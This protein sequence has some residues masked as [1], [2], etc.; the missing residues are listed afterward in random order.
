M[1]D[2]I[3]QD[4]QGLVSRETYFQMKADQKA[5]QAIGS[6]YRIYR[7][8]LLARRREFYHKIL[9][10][11][12]PNSE[13]CLLEPPAKNECYYD[14]KYADWYEYAEKHPVELPPDC[15][16]TLDS[17]ALNIVYGIVRGKEYKKI[18]QKINEG[19]NPSKYAIHSVCDHYGINTIEFDKT[20][21]IPYGS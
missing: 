3:V 16:L 1:A 15:E 9:Q 18:E 2:T 20:A 4:K 13:L 7:Q 12:V 17:R 5:L 11:V 10:G 21:G 8:K 14:A 19:N 6:A